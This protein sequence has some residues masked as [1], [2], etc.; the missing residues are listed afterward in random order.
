M[1]MGNQTRKVA[2]SLCA[3][4]SVT[5]QEHPM[6]LLLD[7]LIREYQ[8]SVTELM[9]AMYSGYFPIREFQLHSITVCMTR[10]RFEDCLE[11][12]YGNMTM[13]LYLQNI[14]K[15]QTLKD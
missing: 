5:N 3:V 12:L 13:I 10:V 6:C 9:S 7:T 11:L 15:P 8:Q 4:D 2:Q 14:L 1:T